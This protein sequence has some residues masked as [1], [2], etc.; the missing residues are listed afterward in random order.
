MKA[1]VILLLTLF[2][3]GTGFVS[4]QTAGNANGDYYYYKG[5][6]IPVSLDRL[7]LSV[8]TLKPAP[9]SRIAAQPLPFKS[10]KVDDPKSNYDL[11]IVTDNST[12]ALTNTRAGDPYEVFVSSVKANPSVAMTQPCFITTE[13]KEIATSDYLYVKLKQDSDLDKVQNLAREYKLEQIGQN[14]FMPLWITLRCTPQTTGSCLAVAN[15]IFETGMFAAAVPDFL[16]DDLNCANDPMFDEQWGL[17]NPSYPNC[18]ISICDAW[19]N[20][21]GKGIIIAILDQGVELTHQDLRA[22]IYSQSYDSETGTSPSKVYGSHATHC[23]GIAAA[24]KDNGIQIAGVAPQAKIM[25]VSNTLNATADS[26]IKRADGINWAWQH[27]AAVISNSWGSSVK[28]EAID[29][30]IKNALTKGRGGKG[31]LVC[32]SSGNE[33]ASGVG[34]PANCN[35]DILAVGS[36]SQNGKRTAFSNYGTALDVVAPGNDI[37][38]TLPGNAVGTMSGTSMACPHVAGAAALLLENNPELTA[39]QANNIIEQS[40]KKIGGYAYAK[41]F[42]RNNGTWNNEMGYGLIDAAA[43]SSYLGPYSLKAM[44]KVQEESEEVMPQ[45]GIVSL[46]TD[47][48]SAQTVVRFDLVTPQNA[49]I[50][51]SS[52]IGGNESYTYMISEGMNEITVPTSAFTPGFYV[53]TLMSD[54]KVID[55]G[56]FVKQ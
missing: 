26:R 13:G 55:R 47:Q 38:S 56:K 25:S 51:I 29:D 35:A 15:R 28:F 7:H 53:V 14:E 34:Y 43:I 20:A 21:T 41:T 1:K 49:Q 27:G 19:F 4:S 3:S 5:D 22:N 42:G 9:N 32:F 39:R 10:R 30:A 8:F 16:S 37:L 36:I 17:Y 2:L 40:T 54:G 18:D 45:E 31:T 12:G 50:R 52:M 24:A 11:T 33:Y 44:Q 23:A 48:A 6:R 46:I